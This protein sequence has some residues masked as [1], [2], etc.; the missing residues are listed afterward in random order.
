MSEKFLTIKVENYVSTIIF[1]LFSS[2]S[3]P[4]DHKEEN[5]AKFRKLI[6]YTTFLPPIAPVY[7]I[8]YNFFQIH[9][10]YCYLQNISTIQSIKYLPSYQYFLFI[11]MLIVI[12]VKVH[13]NTS[14][15][16]FHQCMT[17]IYIHLFF[18]HLLF[19]VIIM[20]KKFLVFPNY[21]LEELKL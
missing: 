8:Y 18:D 14:H 1:N 21:L 10:A 5:K 20:K 7:Y 2:T 4:Q 9:Y 17:D 15:K 12:D 13:I 19:G 11:S 3:G 16:M 6:N